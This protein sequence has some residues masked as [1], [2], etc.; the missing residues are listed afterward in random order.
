MA[1]GAVGETP[2]TRAQRGAAATWGGQRTRPHAHRALA[3]GGAGRGT[4]GR[5]TQAGPRGPWPP[6]TAPPPALPG[7]PRHL[8]WGRTLGLTVLG[9]SLVADRVQLGLRPQ[10][11]SRWG[12]LLH[13]HPRPRHSRVWVR[14]GLNCVCSFLLTSLVSLSGISEA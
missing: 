4:L 5:T 6:G 10:R 7:C 12:G 9:S 14:T 1:E 2:L 11:V 13:A 3:M 8:P